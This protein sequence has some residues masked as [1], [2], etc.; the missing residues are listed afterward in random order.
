MDALSDPRAFLGAQEK[1]IAQMKAM[2]IDETDVQTTGLK[3]EGEKKPGEKKKDEK[4]GMKM[5]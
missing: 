5:K 3:L 1:R 2:G 4:K